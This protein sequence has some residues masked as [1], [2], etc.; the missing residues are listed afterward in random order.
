MTVKMQEGNH[1]KILEIDDKPDKL[2][3]ELGFRNAKDVLKD[4]LLTEI[5]HRISRFSDEMERF[6]EKIW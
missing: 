3:E 4:S 2:I 5:F 6:E 1:V